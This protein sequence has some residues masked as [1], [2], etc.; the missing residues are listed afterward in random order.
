MSDYNYRDD[1]RKVIKETRWTIGVVF[2]VIVI[3][4]L[5]LGSVGGLVWHFLMKPVQVLDQV[6]D[7]TRMLEGY[8]WFVQ[9]S[10]DIENIDPQIANAKDALDRFESRAG[11]PSKYSM[12]QQTEDDRLSAV[13]LG[14]KQSRQ[15]MVAAYNAR[16]D[17]RTR[18]FL[19]QRGLPDHYN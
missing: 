5:L 7:P 12:F 3:P 16:S 17:E 1:T 18:S 10:K 6:T 13:L 19:K 11:D 8:E 9:Q 4:I 15:A 14:L 2:L